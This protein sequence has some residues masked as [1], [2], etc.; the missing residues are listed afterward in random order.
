MFKECSLGSL[1]LA[2]RRL[3]ESE[4]HVGQVPGE[5]LD[6]IGRDPSVYKWNRLHLEIFWFSFINLR[7][8]LWI[9]LNDMEFS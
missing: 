3:Y 2:K 4:V 5:I 9:S 1:T 7:Y 6:K 8:I